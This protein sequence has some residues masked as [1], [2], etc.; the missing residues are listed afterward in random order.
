[1][2]QENNNSNHSGC[3]YYNDKDKGKGN[4]K[5]MDL[6]SFI[7]I[8]HYLPTGMILR[9]GSV[10]KKWKN[11]GDS[12][13]L[14]IMILGLELREEVGLSKVRNIK[15]NRQIAVIWKEEFIEKHKGNTVKEVYMKL[16]RD[17][18]KW[19]DKSKPGYKDSMRVF[20]LVEKKNDDCSSSKN[21]YNLSLSSIENPGELLRFLYE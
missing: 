14:W 20:P 17:K 18:I 15:L 2:S 8:C 10:C 21:I 12:D 6:N 7:R 1:M 5:L 16:R 9:C 4:N 11:L 3:E 19:T 13:D